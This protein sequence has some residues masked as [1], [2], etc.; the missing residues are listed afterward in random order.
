MKQHFSYSDAWL[1]QHNASH[2][3]REICHQPRLWRE[4]WQSLANNQQC[5]DFLEPLLADPQLHIILTGAGSSA[6]VGKALAPWLREKTGKDVQAYATTD[7]VATP[8]A[9]LSP[10]KKTLLVSFARSGN[11]P[12][13]VAAVQ[14]A[15]Q[16]VENCYHLMI[17][18]NPKG[19]LAHYAEGKDHV[20]S[21]IMPE[22]SN[23]QSFAMTS[24][25]S[26][27]MLATILVLGF[28]KRETKADLEQMVTVCEQGLID[29]QEQIKLLAQ[30]GFKRI[31]Y[32]GSHCFTG[33]TEEAALK[34]LE[35]TAGKIT[36][37][38]DS[39]LGLRHGPKF[40]VDGSA[41]VV[42]LLSNDAYIRQYD[43]DLLNEIR[44]DGLA[45]QVMSL[46]GLACT[47]PHSLHVN[48][49]QDDIW[50][51]FPYLVFAQMLATECS[52]ALALTP[53][54]PCPTGE[55]NRVVKGVTIY[56]FSK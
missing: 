39:S 49:Q 53:D 42:C 48:S 15:E 8:L 31:L 27:M 20:Y 13:S 21:L 1:E 40:M 37:R 32:I 9:F 16:C 22:G 23:D 19:E 30:Q 38:F 2:T 26:C 7:I 4:L 45:K 25:F 47:E 12:E 18:C 55:V 35:L 44:R 14:L 54:N 10:K 56:P 3:I 34:M 52:L 6:F 46:S 51:L 17:T 43:I 33:L 11:S 41:L 24:S 50:L 28:V 36:T 29:W 5:Q